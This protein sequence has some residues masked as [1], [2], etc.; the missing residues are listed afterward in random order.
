M[1]KTIFCLCIAFFIV[2]FLIAQEL[3]FATEVK[4]GFYLEYET[5][6]DDEGLA[7]GG[8]LNNDGDLS[9]EYIDE[10]LVPY[11]NNI[12]EYMIKYVIP[13]AFAFQLA[14]AYFR[15]CLCDATF[16]MHYRSMCDIFNGFSNA[17]LEVSD[18]TFDILRIKYH[19]V[20]TDDSPMKI[21]K[22]T[23]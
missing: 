4:T 7:K 22:I 23:D 17:C 15:G 13:D 11:D 3:T 2:P 12:R 18:A 21:E 6:G 9:D 19:L 16:E 8:M 10:H 1:K 14:N 5:I 20:I